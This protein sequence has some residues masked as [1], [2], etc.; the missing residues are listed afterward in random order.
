MKQLLEFFV[1]MLKLRKEQKGLGQI[2]SFIWDLGISFEKFLISIHLQF[3]RF[4]LQTMLEWT[5]S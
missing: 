2:F 5:Q 3:F 1:G 4:L